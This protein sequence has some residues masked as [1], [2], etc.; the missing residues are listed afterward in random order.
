MEKT[1]AGTPQ[2]DTGIVVFDIVQ[3]SACA[4][5]RC[6]LGEGSFLRMENDKPVRMTCADLDKKRIRFYLLIDKGRGT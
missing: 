3:D 5:C 4:E 6:T 1:A 2:R